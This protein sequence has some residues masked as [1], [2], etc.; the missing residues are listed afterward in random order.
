MWIG[1]ARRRLDEP[2]SS[3]RFRYAKFS[4][5]CLALF[6]P[7][8][9]GL[10]AA[11]PNVD[12][13]PIAFVPPFLFFFVLIGLP[14]A[15]LASLLATL[16]FVIGGL[17]ARFLEANPGARTPWRRVQFA[18]GGMFFLP[19]FLLGMYLFVSG[20][21]NRE[22]PAFRRGDLLV[23]RAESDPLL[24]WGSILAWGAGSALLFWAILTAVRGVVD[25]NRVL[26][27]TRVQRATGR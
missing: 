9:V 14:L 16:G 26:R 5:A 22:V 1:P 11:L 23:L 20:L 18:L 2:V 6:G 10:I 3:Y 19:F 8:L 12:K 15:T 21:I 17:W 25:P 24:Y 27:R 7:L 13:L 4:F